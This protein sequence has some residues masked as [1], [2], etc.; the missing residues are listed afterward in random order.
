[1]RLPYLPLNLKVAL[2]YALFGGL[3]ILLSDHLLAALIHDPGMQTNLQTVKGWAFVAL[4]AILIDTLLR[5]HLALNQQA[6]HAL[7]TSEERYRQLF[8]HSMD[9]ILLTAPDG[10]I[11]SANPAACRIFQ[12]SEHELQQLG[13]NGLVEANDL[14]L[15][16][17]L[18]ERERNG[19][20]SG[21]L[22]FQR[23]DGS[24]FEGEVSTVCFTNSAGQTRTSMIIRDVTERKRMAEAVMSAR[25]RLS[26]VLDSITD[27]FVTLDHDWRITYINPEAAR[28][29]KKR[30]EEFLGKTH[31]EEWPASLGSAVEEQYRRAVAQRVA[32]HFEHRYVVAGQY[33]TW[34]DIH[35]YPTADG[36]TL[37]Y[38]DISQ[39]KRAEQALQ[40]SHQQLQSL[41]A[42]LSE[43]EEC[44]RH[45]LARELHDRVGQSLTALSI[46]LN[47][48]QSQL[49][50]A[51]AQQVG[52]RLADS[53]QLIDETIERVRDVMANLY[54]PVL[55]DY[56]LAAALR[57]YGER[58]TRHT[59]I[60]VQVE[61]RGAVEARLPA[62][63][64][65]VLFRVAQEA[66][67][68]VARHAQARQIV[69]ELTLGATTQL[70]IQ[71][72]GRG[73]DSAQALKTDEHGGWG[74]RTMRERVEAVGGS[75]E[76]RSAHG[77]GTTVCA[78]VAAPGLA[79]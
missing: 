60:A 52:T 32:V 9:A 39:R 79:E 75:L 78:Q 24:T 41:T 64:E 62:S 28:I 44:E 18:A 31:W 29:N 66:L 7:R 35:A 51:S 1:M 20:F 46:N 47:I 34:L 12:C 27:A 73:F 69:I 55:A 61:E 76:L 63:L 8:E 37:F 14:R 54:P 36:L 4:S 71:D 42:R 53:F 22:T 72:D 59:A 48:V 10:R 21:E 26:H 45:N 11:D 15:E 68:N 74:L 50:A 56:G 49:S 25:D 67:N 77:Q 40:Q 3:W 17:A 58:F 23:G 33:D 19:R 5:R 13:R 57:W 70:C 65:A 2:T 30:P 16:P 43:V 6:E 38:R